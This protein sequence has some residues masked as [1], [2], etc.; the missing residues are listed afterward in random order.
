M[1]NKHREQSPLSPNYGFLQRLTHS[2]S[3]SPLSKVLASI[4]GC[5]SS[6]TAIPVEKIRAHPFSTSRNEAQQ[7]T[8]MVFSK[9]Y[10]IPNSQ[11]VAGV[12]FLTYLQ[13]TTQVRHEPRT[14]NPTKT[15]IDK[16]SGHPFHPRKYI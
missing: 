5:T 15:K 13:T 2:H 3:K 11:A 10:S 8:T 16:R 9:Q 12:E 7:V 6:L 4:W 1:G 14:D